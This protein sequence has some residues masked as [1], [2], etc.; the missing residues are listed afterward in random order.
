MHFVNGCGSRG[1]LKTFADTD[2]AL[3]V[4]SEAE[5]INSEPHRYYP[6]PG[7]PYTN[8]RIFR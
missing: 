6:R 7:I 5:E 4:G 3:V 8:D 1:H 2:N